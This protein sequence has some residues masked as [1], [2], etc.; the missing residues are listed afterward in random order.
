MLHRAEIV[1]WEVLPAIRAQ[2]VLELKLIG[3]KQS[4][5]AKLLNITPSAISQYVNNKRAD[6]TYFSDDFKKKIK[7]SAKKIN[8][9]ISSV[10]I[11]TN[12]LI[13]EFENE[14]HICIVCRKKN[15]IEG[16]C[17]ICFN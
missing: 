5:I 1:Y 4:E 15:N 6:K 8:E 14:K 16:K 17:G 12:I 11:E 2:L 9:N 10:F 3:K 7:N 13:K